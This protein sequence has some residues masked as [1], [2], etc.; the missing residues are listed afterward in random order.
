MDSD[1]LHDLECASA[2]YAALIERAEQDHGFHSS[3][4]KALRREWQSYRKE[5]LAL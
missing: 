5:K 4:A 2:A 3:E 1:A